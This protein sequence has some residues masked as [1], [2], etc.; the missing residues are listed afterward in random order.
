MNTRLVESHCVPKSPSSNGEDRLI[1]VDGFWG[2]VDGSSRKGDYAESIST[3]AALADA[4]VRG[5]PE[6]PIEADSV[7]AIEVLTRVMAAVAS[8][9]HFNSASIV[10]YSE[11]RNEVWALGSGGFCVDGRSEIVA[12]AHEAAAARTRAAFLTAELRRGEDE[13][14]LAANDPGRDLIIGLLRQERYLRNVDDEGPYFY[15]ALDGRPVP[16]RHIVSQRLPES[17]HDITLVTDGYPVVLPTLGECEAALSDLL[18]T[19]RLLIGR[20]PQTKPVRPGDR[21]FD[22]RALIHLRRE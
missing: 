22:D 3:G 2:V 11:H 5:M 4:V 12:S 7:E 21:S 8:P 6:V 18:S 16:A 19:D 13:G 10:L 17:A 14:A 9:D 20:Y 1:I 15:G